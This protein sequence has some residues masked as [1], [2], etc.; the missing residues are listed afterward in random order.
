[1]QTPRLSIGSMLQISGS[2]QWIHNA[3]CAIDSNGSLITWYCPAV[4]DRPE[5]CHAATL[6]DKLR[7]HGAIINGADPHCAIHAGQ[8]YIS[9]TLLKNGKYCISI[10]EHNRDMQQVHTTVVAEGLGGLCDM[11][12]LS[13]ISG[14]VCSTYI[15]T[16]HELTTCFL[17][18]RTLRKRL[19][20]PGPILEVHVASDGARIIAAAQ[21]EK[22][23]MVLRMEEHGW[24]EFCRITLGAELSKLMRWTVSVHANEAMV[25]LDC[26]SGLWILKLDLRTGR[27]SEP[28]I[29][30]T[31][32]KFPALARTEVGWV[33]AWAG[34]PPIEL[35]LQHDERRA[36]RNAVQM[37]RCMSEIHAANI[38]S[39]LWLGSLDAAG[40]CTAVEGPLADVNQVHFGIEIAYADPS[41]ILLWRSS[42]P[43][44]T[45]EELPQHCILMCRT[46]TIGAQ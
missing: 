36:E 35:N 14:D 11:P 41:G 37:A 9:S 18:G 1:M 32:G 40:R 3:F 30:C 10:T 24:Q 5:A 16:E 17:D 29:I 46:F 26:T 28:A 31:L 25:A 44:L 6:D 27:I 34:A 12:L 21:L 4:D 7:G 15:S 38:W 19:S 39:A 43:D 45:E 22:S 42:S 20:A 13:V 33:L 23:I 8:F 2:D